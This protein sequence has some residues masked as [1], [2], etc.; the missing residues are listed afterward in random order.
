MSNLLHSSE[1]AFESDVLKYELPVLV[2]FW[3][4]WCG[5]CKVVG[6]I[7]EDLSKEYEGRMRFVKVDVDQNA[8]LAAKY[9][10]Q[11]IPTLLFFKGGQ[12]VGRT[13]G[14]APRDRLVQEIDKILTG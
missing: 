13:V 3:A 9:G 4:E 14:A 2:D 10:I 1:H 7:I 6:P 12:E 11:G 8:D 5:P